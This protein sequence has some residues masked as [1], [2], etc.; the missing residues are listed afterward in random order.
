MGA[1]TALV[2]V[3]AALALAPAA[4]Q[5]GPSANTAA[6]Q[7]ALRALSRYHGKID[8]VAGP[9]TRAAVRAFQ[10]ARRLKV[11]GVAGPRTRRALGRRGRPRLGSRIMRK[12]QRGWDVAGLQF[13]LRYRG[14]SPRT[15]DG[16]FGPRTLRSVK[17]FQR[18]RGLVADGRAG[19]A[20]LRALRRKG[21]RSS[22]SRGGTPRGPVRFLRPVPGPI[23]DGFGYPG[24]RRHDGLDYPVPYGT[25]IGAAGR[26]TVEFAGWNSGGYGNLIVIRHRRGFQTWYAHLASFSVGAGRRVAGG[27]RIGRVGSTG[28]STGPHLHFEVRRNGVP[29]NPVPYLLA[30]TSL[31]K[32]AFP[33]VESE[34]EN[35]GKAT[36]HQPSR[37]QQD[38]RTARLASC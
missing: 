21:R 16:G 27:V 36:A 17:A 35:H 4:A 33:P 30:R 32:I 22:G 8:G 38:P 1:V 24:G 7:V 26:G 3:C 19:R 31:G 29:I 12:G 10:R 11:D 6:L 13:L 20:T 25:S 28:R 23:G 15:I 14:F 37:L 5:A 9:R 2:V 18:A 34:C